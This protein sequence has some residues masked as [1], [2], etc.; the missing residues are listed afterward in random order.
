MCVQHVACVLHTHDIFHS[1][2]KFNAVFLKEVTKLVWLTGLFI[3]SET[4]DSYVVNVSLL[5][6]TSRRVQTI[7]PI[8]ID[9]RFDFGRRMPVLCFGFGQTILRPC[10]TSFSFLSPIQS[11]WGKFA[12]T[13]ICSHPIMGLFE[14]LRELRFRV[15]N[16]TARLRSVEL[17]CDSKL[18]KCLCF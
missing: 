10:N 11:A 12:K 16:L 6:D 3:F 14:L 15:Q 13:F 17:I 9:L 1:G 2:F 7:S 4:F 8:S 5:M 18:K